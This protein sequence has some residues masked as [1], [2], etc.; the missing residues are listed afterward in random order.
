MDIVEFKSEMSRLAYQRHQES[1]DEIAHQLNYFVLLKA[2]EDDVRRDP[3]FPRHAI[4]TR[5]RIT[6]CDKW[7]S[8]IGPAETAFTKDVSAGGVGL[9]LPG[10]LKSDY[11]LIEF[12]QHILS[13]TMVARLFWKLPADDMIEAGGAFI[14]RL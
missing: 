1:V 3:K 7:L 14:G 4:S 8:P 2:A 5:V 12:P 9:I 13:C 11:L 6:P 10:T